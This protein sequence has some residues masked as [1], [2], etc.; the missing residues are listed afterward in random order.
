MK[1]QKASEARPKSSLKS[2]SGIYKS[3]DGWQG[4]KISDVKLRGFADIKLSS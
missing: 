2:I 3:V 4:R 1:T